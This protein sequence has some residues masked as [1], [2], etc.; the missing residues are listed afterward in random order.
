MTKNTMD[1]DSLE[2]AIDVIG[3]ECAVIAGCFTN[4]TT[5]GKRGRTYKAYGRRSRN[6]L[7]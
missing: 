6:D 4:V 1:A 3:P 7:E 2:N 5:N